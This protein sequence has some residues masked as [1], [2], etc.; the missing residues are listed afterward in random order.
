MPT[1]KGFAT[2]ILTRLGWLAQQP[3]PLQRRILERLTI[4]RYA[5]KEAVYLV[6]D[7]PGG[8]F[9]LVAGTLAVA[10]A[11]GRT[12]PHVAHLAVPGAWFGEGSFLTGGTRRIGLEA[13]T[14]CTLAS[15]PLGEMRRLAA[16]DPEVIR[17]FAQIAMLNIDLA[18]L[19]LVDLLI[20]DPARRIAAVAWRGAG[21]QSTYRLAVTQSQLGHLANASRKQTLAALTRLEAIGAIRRGYGAVEI[22][23][24]ELLRRFADGAG[25][26]AD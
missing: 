16:E 2:A 12:G 17:S 1:E 9:G 19:A 21:G 13:V 23:D 3:E 25:A 10:I 5:A 6:G 18:L 11:P 26:P 20:P 4:R 24:A 14:E 22:A 7:P 15:L 8:I